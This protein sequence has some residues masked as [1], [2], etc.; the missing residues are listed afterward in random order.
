MNTTQSI[1]IIIV[2]IGLILLTVFPIFGVF[3]EIFFTISFF[4]GWTIS[5]IGA[6]IIIASLIQE[7]M[8]DIKKEK[9][10]KY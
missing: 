3:G 4:G 6:G 5:I 7:R 1:G 10:D 9:F 8:N 2:I